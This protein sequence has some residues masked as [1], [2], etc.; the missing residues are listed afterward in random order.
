MDDDSTSNARPLHARRFLS[1]SH[2]KG[3][4]F[5]PHHSDDAPELQPSEKSSQDDDVMDFLRP[6]SSDTLTFAAPSQQLGRIDT[7][8]A[9]RWPSAAEVRR[10]ATNPPSGT[11]SRHTS[12]GRSFSP[13][14]SRKGL[15]VKFTDDQPEIIGEGG[16]E[17]DRAP[18]EVSRQRARSHSPLPQ[19]HRAG[20]S[21]WN[22]MFEQQ[23][24]TARPQ[25]YST[26]SSQP[27]QDGYQ[28][29]QRKPIPPAKDLPNNRFAGTKGADIG[30]SDDLLSS[31]EP[32]DPSVRLPTTTVTPATSS[33]SEIQAKMRAEEGKALHAALRNASP[34][35]DD[36]DS[37]LAEPASTY[38]NRYG[39]QPSNPRKISTSPTPSPRLATPP[40]LSPLTPSASM[41]SLPARQAT[42]AAKEKGSSQ[43]L[44]AFEQG[45]RS[46][47]S[48]SL[49]FR[50]ASS[51]GDNEAFE[52]FKGRVEHLT[53]L[54]QLAADSA[55]PSMETT[56]S[57]WLSA[58][59]WWFLKGRGGLESAI[60][61]QPSSASDGSKQAFESQQLNQA[62]A[63]LAKAWWMTY[64]VIP[65]LP[66]LQDYGTDDMAVLIEVA[67]RQGDSST[68]ELVAIN[69]DII[70]QLR[71]L[72]LS[73]QKNGFL[74]RGADHPL[75]P[76]GIDTG[77][78]VTYPRFAPDVCS[79]LSGQASYSLMD[80]SP[81][82]L[83][84]LEETM[85][86]RDCVKSFSYGRISVDAF[87]SDQGQDTQAFKLPCMLSM[88]RERT[89]WDMSI[90]IASQSA[91]V[92]LLVQPYGK[93]GTTWKDV[94][95]VPRREQLILK[96]PRGFTLTIQCVERDFRKLWSLYDST[97]KVQSSLNELPNEALIFENTVKT[98]TYMVPG[99]QPSSF[100]KEPVSRC[101]LRL[102]EKSISQSEGTGMR[103]LH[104][105][106]RLVV[107]TSPRTKVLSK[108]SHEI[109]GAYPLVFAFLRGPG[110]EQ[111]LLLKLG[112]EQRRCSMVLTFQEG[113]ERGY[114]LSLLNGHS[115]KT[116]ETFFADVPCKDFS[117]NS[118]HQATDSSA[119]DK[120]GLK[121]FGWH[122]LRV[123]NKDPTDP[124]L[125]HGQTVLSEALRICIESKAGTVTDRVNLGRP[126]GSLAYD[127]M[128]AN[129]T[130]FRPR[131]ASMATGRR[132]AVQDRSH[133]RS[134]AGHDHVCRR[135]L[136]DRRQT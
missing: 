84:S 85:P 5:A 90:V 66:T 62:F 108:A 109:G 76:Q 101:R 1:K 58:A 94:Q 117:F 127:G 19:S 67:K 122:Q 30:I 9:S 72:T 3:K 2:W 69:Q 28:P 35:K 68:A 102:F 120:V 61:S 39:Q 17:A 136:H 89:D 26:S 95:W 124:D 113:N 32:A 34:P 15:S 133:A 112:D 125:S 24:S 64:H 134:A 22:Q 99:S 107:I 37:L 4:I 131:A 110:G 29:S 49:S 86:I 77:I 47:N 53:R 82:Q 103:K 129:P 23:S 60:R 52:I 46:A 130:Y 114:L 126:R 48:S 16:D 42:S 91:L 93:A 14:R 88:L 25:E 7:A 44:D 10:S 6:S 83:L 40:P 59:L 57:D 21:E 92:C 51:A 20:P 27:Y 121:D 100:P 128:K 135:Q 81:K 41:L 33:T 132:L 118:L 50:P 115:A 71:A 105:G 18:A 31:P 12:R 38:G 75:L 104:R 8:K 119:A 111:A 36:D 106:F 98:F 116:D 97:Q 73:M 43:Y 78:W 96:L 11:R 54:F 56:L 79:V 123:I 74:G 55:R 45:G 80:D 65:Q 70:G 13:K 63:D 87:L